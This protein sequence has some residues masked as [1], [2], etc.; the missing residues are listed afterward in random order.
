[1]AT[2]IKLWKVSAALVGMCIA[3]LCLCGCNDDVFIERTDLT[4]NMSVRLDG[5][6]DR[7]GVPYST[8][9]LEYV[10]IEHAEYCPNFVFDSGHNVIEE[11]QGYSVR[12][13]AGQ[14]CWV[15]VYGRA[16]TLTLDFQRKDYLDIYCNQNHS[17]EPFTAKVLFHYPSRERV[18]EVEITPG[19]LYTV[20]YVTMDISEDPTVSFEER[21]QPTYTVNNEGDQNVKI[22]IKP[23][24]NVNCSVDIEIPDERSAMIDF[25]SA[26]D[27][28]VLS[29]SPDG[30][31]TYTGRSVKF[32][33]GTQTVL[34]FGWGLE[35]VPYI[36]P[37]HTK[38]RFTVTLQYVIVDS[39]M[40]FQCSLPSGDYFESKALMHVVD[41]LEYK[42]SYEVI[43]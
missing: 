30:M 5:A 42:I 35:A 14:E 19:E 20:D 36:I 33:P 29:A 22:F 1:M 2:A 9:G 34:V 38:V 41:P 24:E 15:D 37:P 23:Y 10:S 25:S 28:D 27:V 39:Y 4:R 16:V 7:K 43:K 6:G 3:F 13:D 12:L 11:T 8:E 31:L 18:I 17:K 32:E 26:P 40:T 21:Q